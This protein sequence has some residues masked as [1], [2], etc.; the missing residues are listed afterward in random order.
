MNRY[1]YSFINSGEL[2]LKEY[3]LSTQKWRTN[4]T[5]ISTPAESN[6]VKQHFLTSIKSLQISQ[7]VNSFQKPSSN[8]AGVYG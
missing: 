6:L 2:R 7:K 4:D 3:W 5:I 1:G 8:V